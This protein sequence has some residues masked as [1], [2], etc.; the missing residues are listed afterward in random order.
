[1]A[2]LPQNRM[3]QSGDTE[4]ADHPNVISLSKVRFHW[5]QK[6]M[7]WYRCDQASPG[8]IGALTLFPWVYLIESMAMVS[9]DTSD[10]CH[11]KGRAAS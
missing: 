6:T 11:T 4:P 3:W 1:M 8:R 5:D 10:C 7:L 2:L 9:V